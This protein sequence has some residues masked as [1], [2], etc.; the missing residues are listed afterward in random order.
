V[1]PYRAAKATKDLVAVI[2]AE[3]PTQ[4]L[5]PGRR[6]PTCR[7]VV[8]TTQKLIPLGP[9]VAT[10]EKCNNRWSDGGCVKWHG[11]WLV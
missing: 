8:E 2:T 1:I 6:C 10:C 4:S 5:L 7:Q 3:C 9:E 11:W